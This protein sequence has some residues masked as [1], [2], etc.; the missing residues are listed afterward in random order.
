[1]KNITKLIVISAI[2]VSCGAPTVIPPRQQDMVVDAELRGYV[3]EF[4]T[5]MN[6]R[7]RKPRG[8]VKTITLESNVT[9]LQASDEAI[10]VCMPFQWIRILK[11][12]VEDIK[13]KAVM[14]HEMGHCFLGLGH[15]EDTS[16][17]HI[18]APSEMYSVLFLENNWDS[19]V[20][21]M[22]S[23][24]PSLFLTE[25]DSYENSSCNYHAK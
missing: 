3:S 2:T 25:G 16:K 21:D 14:F 4:I 10:G 9:A 15:N 5:E 8:Y 6:K 1:M 18:M 19:L 22:F 24:Q 7:N 23:Q 17:H 11:R 12:E 13:N 20:N